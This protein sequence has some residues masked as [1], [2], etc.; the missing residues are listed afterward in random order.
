MN[1]QKRKDALTYIMKQMA[2]HLRAEFGPTDIL[3]CR[4]LREKLVSDNKEFSM[5]LFLNHVYVAN[6]EWKRIKSNIKPPTIEEQEYWG[7]NKTPKG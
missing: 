2:F 3:Y 7:I 1:K 4:L 5:D 6:S